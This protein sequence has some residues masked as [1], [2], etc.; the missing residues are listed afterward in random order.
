[1][2]CLSP[3]IIIRNCTLY[4]GHLYSE[5]TSCFWIYISGSQS[6]S[7]FFLIVWWFWYFNGLKSTKLNK[8]KE[9]MLWTLLQKQLKKDKIKFGQK[10]NGKKW[11]HFSNE[12]DQE[13]ELCRTLLSPNEWE[14]VMCWQGHMRFEEKVKEIGI[15]DFFI[16][17][18]SNN[19]LPYIII[20]NYSGYIHSEHNYGYIYLE[21][22]IFIKI[23][24]FTR[25]NSL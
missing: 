23:Y 22:K 19:I 16:Q 5:G 6:S 12:L 24:C 20:R 14:S 10:C 25:C 11:L 17:N 9:L 18:K 7:T 8:F 2:S 15:L 1:M 4:Y 3:D 21:V 13:I